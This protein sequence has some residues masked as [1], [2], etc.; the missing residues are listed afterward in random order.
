MLRL[1]RKDVYQAGEAE[2]ITGLVPALYA[3]HL[4]GHEP[5]TYTGYRVPAVR[6]SH[7]TACIRRISAN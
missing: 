1:A 3:K 5:G 7:F 4:Q 2:G 6:D